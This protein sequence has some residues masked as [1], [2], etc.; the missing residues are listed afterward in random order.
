MKKIFYKISKILV[1]VMTVLLLLEGVSFTS[2][3][4]DQI[5]TEKKGKLTITYRFK[6]DGEDNYRYF[7][8]IEVSI[9]KIASV[10][11]DKFSFKLD[12]PYNSLTEI[13]LS[14]ITDKDTAA[15]KWE[16]VQKAVEPE[17]I[18]NHEPT[19]TVTTV[20]GK[21]VFENLDLGFAS[22][23]AVVLLVIVMIFSL[24]NILCFERK[25][26]DL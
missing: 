22:A 14:S 4:R 2:Y 15:A 1:F 11:D 20:D 24:I 8:G 10:S 25:K 13:D 3:A 16:A 9:Y 12:P 18:T 19:R 23:M 6:E 17:A 5:D 26:Y 7:S 21:A